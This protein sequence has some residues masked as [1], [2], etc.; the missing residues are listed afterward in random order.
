MEENKEKIDNTEIKELSDDE[1]E[2]VTGGSNFDLHLVDEEKDVVFI[3]P[4]G[5]SILVDEGIFY[6]EIRCTV[7]QRKAFYDPQYGAYTD[8]Y[9]VRGPDNLLRK[10]LRDDV[11]NEAF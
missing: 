5:C 10:I 11:V 9:I 4:I 2:K 1:L 3:F 6:S 7:E 8:M